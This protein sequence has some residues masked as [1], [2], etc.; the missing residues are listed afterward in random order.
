MRVECFGN[1]FM[2]IFE[3]RNCKVV[4]SCIRDYKHKC[5]LIMDDDE[6]YEENL[7]IKKFMKRWY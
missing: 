7:N 1:D 5:R 4:H 6:L 2:K 3:C